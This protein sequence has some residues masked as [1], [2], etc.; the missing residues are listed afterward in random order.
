VK[1]FKE[2]LNDVLEEGKFD[3]QKIQD[4]SKELRNRYDFI[5]KLDAIKFLK[6][7]GYKVDIATK[8]WKVAFGDE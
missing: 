8:A 7:L 2:Y 4:A 1:D 3:K 5:E 6:K